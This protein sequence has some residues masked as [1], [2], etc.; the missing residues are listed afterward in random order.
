VTTTQREISP[1]QIEFEAEPTQITE[2]QT[3]QTQASRKRKKRTMVALR[4]SPRTRKRSKQIQ[5]TTEVVQDATEHP[6]EL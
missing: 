5:E 4:S 2:A 3:S 1:P 6:E